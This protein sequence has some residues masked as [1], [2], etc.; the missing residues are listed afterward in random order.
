[1]P[2]KNISSTQHTSFLTDLLIIDTEYLD[3][4]KTQKYLLVSVGS[5]PM[6]FCVQGGQLDQTSTKVARQGRQRTL[7]QTPQKEAKISA[8]QLCHGT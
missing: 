8:F 6:T 1:M 3:K 4:L 5:E 2:K 7:V